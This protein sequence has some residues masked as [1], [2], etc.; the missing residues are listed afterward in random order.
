M[1]RQIT[2]N[3]LA[4][5][6]NR[7]GVSIWHLQHVENSLVHYI[8]IKGIAKELNSIEKKVAL[9]HEKELNKLTLGQLI[10]RAKKLGIIEDPLLG[11]LQAF[12]NE[13]KWVVHNS[14]FEHGDQL[15]TEEGRT[16][17]FSRLDSFVD[18]AVALHKHIGELMVEYSVSK[19]MSRQ[20]IEEVAL[21]HIRKLK[22]EA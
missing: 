4:Y 10:G 20:G 21:S 17:V 2:Q 9:K 12:N 6:Y 3:E 7:I 13:R 16:F 15:Y 18:E 1:R 22:G 8:I 5:L 14:I 19:G 11:R